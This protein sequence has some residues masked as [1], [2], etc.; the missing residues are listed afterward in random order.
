M[1]GHKKKLTEKGKTCQTEISGKACQNAHSTHMGNICKL[2]NKNKD[3][4]AP[5]EER[6]RSDK[7]KDAFNKAQGAQD[8]LINKE[9]RTASY[10]WY[11]SCDRNYLEMRLKLV[12]QIHSLKQLET[13]K[14]SQS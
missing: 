8:E 13:P 3:L 7:L 6:D 5:E 11:N 10:L 4:K 1:Q 9:D 2:L 12:E 14:L